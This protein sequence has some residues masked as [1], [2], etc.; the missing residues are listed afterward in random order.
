MGALDIETLS[1]KQTKEH[2]HIMFIIAGLHVFWGF[3][4]LILNPHRMFLTT[5]LPGYLIALSTMAFIGLLIVFFIHR[6]APVIDYVSTATYLTTN[7][8]LFLYYCYT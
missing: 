8:H 7:F 2:N 5:Q 3:I 6:R 4:Q 1:G